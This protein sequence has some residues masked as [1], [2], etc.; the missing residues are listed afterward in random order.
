MDVLLN[1]YVQALI[2]IAVIVLGFV[3][4]TGTILTL[5]E[6][7][8]MSAVQDRIGPNRAYFPW[9]GGKRLTLH[10]AF[11]LAADG[12]K[13]MVKEDTIPEGA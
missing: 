3:M 9:F 4:L 6:R 12:L 10:G 8:W 13:S 2:K 7:K 1:P 11:Q 5:M